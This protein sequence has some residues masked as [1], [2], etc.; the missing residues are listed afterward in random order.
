MW[1]CRLCEN[2]N[3]D[4]LEKCEC[5]GATRPIVDYVPKPM[6]IEELKPTPKS[7]SKPKSAPKSEPK[8]APKPKPKEE[9]RPIF[10][11]EDMPTCLPD[12]KF[13]ETLAKLLEEDAKSGTKYTSS[14]SATDVPKSKTVGEDAPKVKP[15]LKIRMNKG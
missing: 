13:P 8:P 15:T 9:E 2:S 12:L 3:V 11:D 14:A 6:R 4:W 1:T 7:E 5:C 10:H